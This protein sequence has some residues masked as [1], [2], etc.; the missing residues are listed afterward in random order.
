[1]QQSQNLNDNYIKLHRI[2]ISLTHIAKLSRTNTKKN[3][4]SF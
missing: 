4:C 3:V 1:M 2:N